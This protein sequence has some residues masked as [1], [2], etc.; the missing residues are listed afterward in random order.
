MEIL[1]LIKVA[2]LAMAPLA[3]KA[4]RKLPDD[5]FDLKDLSKLLS[6]LFVYYSL[7]MIVTRIHDFTITEY[8]IFSYMFNIMLATIFVFLVLKY[9]PLKKE[10]IKS[11]LSFPAID[12]KSPLFLWIIILFAYESLSIYLVIERHP[13]M[14]IEAQAV[15]FYTLMKQPFIVTVV[16]ML[17]VLYSVIGEELIFRYFVINSLKPVYN[18]RLVIVISSVLWM[19]MHQDIMAGRFIQGVFWSYLYVK[20]GRIL[21]C[22]IFHYIYNI[23]IMTQ[24]FYIHFRNSNAINLTSLQYASIIFISFISVYLLTEFIFK[25]K[26]LITR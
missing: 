8:F 4:Y 18:E 26:Q 16:T 1:L 19:I 9:S 24:P 23:A 7:I 6:V 11:I 3:L 21:L 22:I 13:E 20:T 5:I 10:S 25:R 12:K 2:V 15:M 14:A 17:I